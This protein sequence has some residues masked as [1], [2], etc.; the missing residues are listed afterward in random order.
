MPTLEEY[1]LE[2]SR[3][4]SSFRVLR[5]VY[6]EVSRGELELVDLSPPTSLRGYLSRLDYS[7]WFWSVIALSTA[8]LLLI[9]S[10]WAHPALT[11][12][13]YVFGSLFVLYLPGY[14]VVEALYP[15]EGEL[16]PLE[17]LA[18]SI[19]LSLAIV[20]LLG[21]FL[22]YTPWGIRL[23]PVA[24]TLFAFILAVA[25]VAAYRKTIVTVLGAELIRRE[26]YK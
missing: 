10:S 11:I 2:K 14:V 4:R 20:P 18:L 16:S 23:T 7:L 13:R 12:L 1:V 15:S 5:E 19:G 24:Y 3:G 6:S 22:N 17:R 25:V 9:Y 8:T 21:L 26:K